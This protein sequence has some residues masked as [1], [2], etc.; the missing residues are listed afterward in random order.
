M[1]NLSCH[2][3]RSDIKN[4]AGDARDAGPAGALVNVTAHATKIFAARNYF[5]QFVQHDLESRMIMV[6][7]LSLMNT[8]MKKL[9]EL[10]VTEESGSAAD[11]HVFNSPHVFSCE[12]EY[13]KHLKQTQLTRDP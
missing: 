7:I 6:R 2:E 13:Y 4:T 9:F 5:K 8:V 11:D 12:C 10:L 1:H 3:I